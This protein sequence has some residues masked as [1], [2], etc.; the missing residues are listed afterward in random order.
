MIDNNR[1]IVISG[2]KY[3]FCNKLNDEPELFADFNRLAEETFGIR[4]DKVGGEYEPHVLASGNTVCANV[5]VNRIPFLVH[6]KRRFF[7]QLGTVMTKKEYRGLGLSRFILEAVITEWRDQCDA[8]YLFAND[9][10]LDFYP[11]F[12]FKIHTEFEYLYEKPGQ[13][14]FCGKKLFL[15]NPEDAEVILAKY[16]EGNPFSDFTMIENQAVFDFYAGGV[17]RDN[18]FFSEND[19]VII[20]ASSEPGRVYCYDIFGKTD[21]PLEEILKSLRNQKTD[22]VTLG[23][24]PKDKEPFVR[25]E[26]KEDDTTL[27]LLHSAMNDGSVEAEEISETDMFPELSHA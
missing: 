9:S 24:T 18:I 20:F 13:A 3:R 26:H 5:S 25:M 1:H 19:G 10:V 21:T 23:F 15:A 8:L 12:G 11:K 7:I 4:F 14:A 22:T 16:R 17:F 27:F 2:K 6:G